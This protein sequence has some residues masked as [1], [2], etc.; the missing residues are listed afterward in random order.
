M[1]LVLSQS[2]EFCESISANYC[3]KIV[4]CNSDSINQRLVIIGDADKDNLCSLNV[5]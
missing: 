5:W 2:E 1:N 4:L 3:F